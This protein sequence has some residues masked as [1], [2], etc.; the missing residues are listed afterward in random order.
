M[1]AA[2][3]LLAALWLLTGVC[4]AEGTVM[5]AEV[6]YGG[7][8]LCGEWVPIEVEITSQSALSGMLSVKV[9]QESDRYDTVQTP[10]EVAAGETVR[11]HMPI[12]PLV[13][14]RRFD[15]TLTADGQAPLRTNATAAREVDKGAIVVGVLGDPSGEL[16]QALRVTS[17]RDPLKRGDQ[18]DTVVLSAQVFPRDKRE[19]AGFDVIVLDAVDVASLGSEQQALLENWLL[20]GGV[21]IAGAG[22]GATHSLAWLGEHTGVSAQEQ[23]PALGALDAVLTYAGMAEPQNGSAA[24][25]A[26]PDADDA[27]DAERESATTLVYPLSAPKDDALAKLSGACLLAGSQCGQGLV[28]TAG[29]G[30]SQPEAL[31][32]AK[33]AL[34]QR[35]LLEADPQRYNVMANSRYTASNSSF[36]HGLTGMLRV[37]VGTSMLPAAAVLAAYVLIAGTGLYLV[38]K[39][40][41]RS[42]AL[43]ALIPL[44]SIVCVGVIAAISAGLGLNEPAAASFTVAQYDEEGEVTVEE[45]VS[46][47]YPQQTRV[48][49]KA[50]NGNVIERSSGWYYSSYS[51]IDEQASEHDRITLGDAP[52]RELAAVAPWFSQDLVLLG[53]AEPETF[54]KRFTLEIGM[55]PQS[56]VL[57]CKIERAKALLC[58]PGCTVSAAGVE[59]GIHDPYHFSKQFKNV[60][61]LSP[62]AFMQLAG[63]T[64]TAEE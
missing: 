31:E 46:I 18:I 15:I 58:Q 38:M 28:L 48:T 2:M 57:H 52:E 64:D 19:M 25:S 10:V 24:Q 37:S 22:D 16:E 44:S 40:R 29:F 39:R 21:I 53:V 54:R 41:D 12:L 13:P 14:Q 4:A 50:L 5:L 30:L 32:A 45:H 61:G 36:S 43:W 47:A 42:R 33:D 3:A 11:V 20:S 49:I 34:W 59:V 51:E 6:G 9:Y 56:Y 8:L 17:S 35:V 55:P 27:S 63:R 7:T 26:D 1:I 23:T 62:S 60:V